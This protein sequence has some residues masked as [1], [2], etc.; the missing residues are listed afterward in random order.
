MT[1]E[2]LSYNATELLKELIS[3]ESFSMQ[4]D[5]TADALQR[6]FEKH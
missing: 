6:F 1:I 4:E 2:E 3:I 5:K